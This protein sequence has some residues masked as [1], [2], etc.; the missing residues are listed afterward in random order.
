[1]AAPPTSI[2]TS[3]QEPD[4]PADGADAVELAE[5]NGGDELAPLQG[6]GAIV[7]HDEKETRDAMSEASAREIDIPIVNVDKNR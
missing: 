6:D 2:Q 7:P 4:L 5:R 3:G 1:M